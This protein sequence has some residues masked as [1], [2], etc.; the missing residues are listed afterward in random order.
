MPRWPERTIQERFEEKYIPE[1]N[2][3]CWLWFAG[4]ACGYGAFKVAE[5]GEQRAHRVSYLLYKGEIPRGKELDHLC[6]VKC[7]VNPEHLE[8]VTHAEN[9]SRSPIGAVPINGRKTHCKYGHPFAGDNL[10]KNHRRR[11]CRICERAA[12]KRKQIRKKELRRW[13]NI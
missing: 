12:S 5:W 10:R 1:P 4:M 8:A 2:S 13:L 6:R 11:V 3:G 7:C 9:M